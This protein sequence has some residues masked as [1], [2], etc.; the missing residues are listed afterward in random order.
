MTQPYELSAGAR[1]VVLRHELHELEQDM[2]RLA[3]EKYRACEAV[4]D[5]IIDGKLEAEVEQLRLKFN[6]LSAQYVALYDTNEAT[7][8]EYNAL[9]GGGE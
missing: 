1:S 3:D 2:L 8:A 6:T 5:A 4:M 7:V 9:Q